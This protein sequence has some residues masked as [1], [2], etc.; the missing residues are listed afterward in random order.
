[1]KK[2]ASLRDVRFWETARERVY[3]WAVETTVEM[4]Q[5]KRIE[6]RTS[7]AMKSGVWNS[8]SGDKER[9][10]MKAE[11]E[12]AEELPTVILFIRCDIR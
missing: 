5:Q 12:Q 9:G 10:S 1:M 6:N 2:P 11:K 4:S 3:T 7:R 8:L